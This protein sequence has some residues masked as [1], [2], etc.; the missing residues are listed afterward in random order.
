M[1]IYLATYDS[2]REAADKMKRT[3]LFHRIDNVLDQARINADDT[4]YLEKNHCDWNEMAVN[5]IEGILSYHND[6]AVIAWF[7]RRGVRP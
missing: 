5:T 6:K 4:V 1:S 7:V 2:L 3:A